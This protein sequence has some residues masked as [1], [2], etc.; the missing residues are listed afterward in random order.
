MKLVIATVAALTATSASAMDLG[1]GL[2]AGGEA[3]AEYNVDTEA[4]TVTLEPEV[5]YNVYGVDLTA[6]TLLT[7]YEGDFVLGDTLPTVDFEARKTVLGNVD[8]YGGVGYNFEAEA[9]TDVKVG[10]SFSF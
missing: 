9:R 8:V 3:V 10:L 2:T 5:G 6:S 1:F 7:V 4:F